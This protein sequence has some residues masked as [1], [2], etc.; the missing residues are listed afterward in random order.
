[1]NKPAEPEWRPQN[2]MTTIQVLNNA[3]NPWKWSKIEHNWKQYPINDKTWEVRLH[4]NGWA[5][6]LN[7]IAITQKIQKW[8]ENIFQHNSWT[9]ERIKRIIKES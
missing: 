2:L 7:W 9:W 4:I 6:R 3:W 1:M 8:V 5:V